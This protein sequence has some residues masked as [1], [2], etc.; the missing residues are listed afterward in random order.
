MTDIELLL[1]ASHRKVV[2]AVGLVDAS[3]KRVKSFD[4]RRDYTPEQLEPYDALSDRF[5]RA[6]E[7]CIRYFRTYERYKEVVA[8]ET[9]RD[10][11]NKMEKFG[12]IG[13]VE[14][15]IGMRDVRNRIVHNYLPEQLKVL[16]DLMTGVYASEL[17]T[18]SARIKNDA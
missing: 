6:V 17:L 14:L 15:W 1:E 7:T 12:L 2:S 4:P 13:S 10:L 11:L 5:V 3:L 16:F 18:V 8:S 9:Y